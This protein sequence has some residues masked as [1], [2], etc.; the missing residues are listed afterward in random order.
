MPIT[1]GLIVAGGA[2]LAKTADSAISAHKARKEAEEIRNGLTTPRAQVDPELLQMYSNIE[3]QGLATEMPQL[4]GLR[5]RQMSAASGMLGDISSIAGGGSAAKIGALQGLY[6]K[7]ILPSEAE[8]ASQTAGFVENQKQSKQRALMSLLPQIGQERRYAFEQN[9]L[10]PYLRGLAESA[11]LEQASLQHKENMYN[12]L[13]Q[14]GM[15]FAQGPNSFGGTGTTT[16]TVPN[17]IPAATSNSAAMS[18]FGNMTGAYGSNYGAQANSFGNY[19]TPASGSGMGGMWQ[20]QIGNS[21]G[22][23][24]YDP[25][26]GTWVTQ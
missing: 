24:Y 26:F 10:N 12:T 6:E 23:G 16:T 4:A 11:A 22:G 21:F 9:Q 25:T 1:I 3:N 13:I 15:M 2:V 19:G 20:G 17:A 7:S 14:G 18:G 8:M 5:N